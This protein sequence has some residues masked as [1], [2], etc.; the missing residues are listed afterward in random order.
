M[1]YNNINNL[2]TLVTN[3]EVIQQ[4]ITNANFDKYLISDDIIKLAEITH[5]EKPLGREF[6]EEMVTQHA[7][8]SFTAANQTL[9][10]DYLK[11]TLCWFV[12]FELMNDVQNNTTSAGI[13]TNID[14]FSEP[15]DPAMFNMMKQ[16]VFR[17]ANL[18]L[19]DMLDFLND[20]NQVGSYPT[21]HNNA[22]DTD[23]LG[24]SSA[25]KAHGIIFY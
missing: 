13:V 17:K 12:K 8:A 11:R 21:Y 25:N 6:Y 22:H 2:A 18:F 16:D 19:Q 3:I 1:A 14:D 10:D 23:V 15:V 9:F 20:K 4:C 7:G 24:D 5:I